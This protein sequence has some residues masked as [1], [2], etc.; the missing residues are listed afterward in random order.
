ML[1]LNVDFALEDE[2]HAIG[3]RAFFEQDFSLLRD[4]FL[5]VPGEPQAVF[6]SHSLQRSDPLQGGG[7]FFD[8]RRTGRRRGNE[9]RHDEPPGEPTFRIA[10]SMWDMGG[11]IAG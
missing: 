3:G 4:Q 11:M 9:G 5:A 2:D 10:D 6:H 8:R 7:N 1:A